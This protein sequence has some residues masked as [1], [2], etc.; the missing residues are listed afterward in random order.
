MI[1][2]HDPK[3][4]LADLI[5][6]ETRIGQDR[7]PLRDQKDRL[8]IGHNVSYDRSRIKEQ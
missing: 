1:T 4:S 5:P 2:G 3:Y 7:L 8:V 6:L